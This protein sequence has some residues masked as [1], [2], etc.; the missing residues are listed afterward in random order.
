MTYIW[1]MYFNTVYAAPARESRCGVLLEIIKC[2]DMCVSV[3]ME[4]SSK[5]LILLLEFCSA[6]WFGCAV[7]GIFSLELLLIDRKLFQ[8]SDF[9]AA[10]F[11]WFSFVPLFRSMSELCRLG[12]GKKKITEWKSWFYRFET[13]IVMPIVDESSQI[14]ILQLAFFVYVVFCCFSL[15]VLFRLLSSAVLW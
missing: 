5:V 11:P 2:Y 14:L 10:A 9:L 1:W 7:V 12:S 4:E 3:C 13:L 6:L 8:F 15:M